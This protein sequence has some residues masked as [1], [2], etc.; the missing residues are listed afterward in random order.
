MHDPWK[1]EGGSGGGKR[2][3]VKSCGCQLSNEEAKPSVKGRIAG[4]G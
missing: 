2:H 4:C 1:R 3:I